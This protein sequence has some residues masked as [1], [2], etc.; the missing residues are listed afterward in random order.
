MTEGMITRTV[1][2]QSIPQKIEWDS[3]VPDSKMDI[4]KILSQTLN[5]H[6]NDYQIKDNLFLANITVCANLL[7][8]PEGEQEPQI[9]SL[10]HT[11][12]LQVKL[13]LP[14]DITWDC[15]EVLF[16]VTPHS[17]VLINSRKA[18]IRGQLN[19][20]VKLLE[21]VHLNAPDCDNHTLETLTET[22]DT[23]ST[24]VL[25][26]DQFPFTLS[27]PLPGGKPPV[28]EILETSVRIHNGDLKAISNKAVIKGDLE[29]KLLYISTLSSVETVEFTSP[30]TE[31]L[32][33]GDL[34][35][36]YVTTFELTPFI[37]T[38]TS[39]ENEANEQK[40]ISFQ[41]MITAQIHAIMPQRISLVTDAYSFKYPV[42]LLK[43][44]TS[45]EQCHLL[46]QENISLK[47]MITLSDSQLEEIL[48]VTCTPLLSGAK[49]DNGQIRINGVLSCR[50]LYR[51][52]SGIHCILKEVPF[53]AFRDLPHD[54]LC[55]DISAKIELRH[56]SYHILNQNNLEI[57]SGIT[58]QI[59]LHATK[60]KE[61]IDAILLNEETPLN[62]HR[63][64]IVAY[65]I[66]P[67]DTLFNIAKKYATTV[68]RLKT[69]N[70][71]ENDRNLKIGSY[72]IIE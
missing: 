10:K 24:P 42:K 38:A 36:E 53:E 11:D 65:I 20:T 21:N 8:L 23:Y 43:K 55:S 7:Y 17:P 12:T 26:Q 44:S 45:F 9:A 48:D 59:C 30:F 31:I 61:Y 69:V 1:W 4:L 66:K 63:A 16:N 57:R 52:A 34:E 28:S 46:P 47:E 18:G 41:G 22:V 40:N 64:P 15:T 50:I 27:F 39:M 54:T 25:R 33:V 49:A 13:E 3:N 51:T 14:P 19:L 56:F 5:A 32:D 60:E 6:M 2:S 72:L 37:L 70:S 29:V 62:I 67:G 35:E 71:I 58:Y 68:D